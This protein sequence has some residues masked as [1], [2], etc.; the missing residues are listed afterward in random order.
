MDIVVANSGTN[1]IGI[2]LSKIDGTFSNQQT[3]PTGIYSQP[4]S[5]VVNDFNND[6]YL[7]IAVAN[8]GTNNI[9]IFRGYG[10]GS[11][12]SQK[13]FS[14]G[15]S[16]PLFIKSG[17]FN[18]DNRSDIAVANYG[19]NNIGVFLGYGNGSFQNQI[20]SFTGYDSLLY[21]LAVADFNEDNHLDIAIANY[22]IDN[23]GIFLGYGNGSFQSQNT[24][25]TGYG[26]NPSSI[27]VGDFNDDNHLDIVVANNGTGNVGILLGFGNGMF[28]AQT[29]YLININSYPQYIT[30]GDFNKDGELDVAVVNSENDE[31]YILLGSGNGTFATV[32]TYDAISESY[33]ISIAVADFDKDN[34]SD[35]FVAN[36]G[37]NNV[38]VLN[39]YT[40]EPSA[41]QTNYSFGNENQ[42]GSVVV[43]D[44]NNDNYLDIAATGIAK[45]G[46]YLLMGNSNGTF[47]GDMGFS[48][49]I[50][51]LPQQLSANDLNHDNRTDIITVNFG[52]DSVGVLLGQDKGI[53]APVMI[54]STGIGSGPSR[55][56]IADV[57]NDN[58][59]DIITANTNID[60]VGVLLG[61]GNGSFAKVLTFS[62]DIGSRPYAVAVGD[63]NNDNHLDILTANYDSES[64]CILFGDGNST[65][66]IP[67]IFLM[68]DNAHPIS[69]TVA[70]FNSDNCLD[71]ALTTDTD[72]NLHVLF[73]DGNGNFSTQI[74]YRFGSASE[75]MYVI[76]TDFNHDNQMDIVSTLTGID[77]VVILLGYGNGSFQD[78]K[79]Y[80]TGSGSLPDWLAFGDFN[81]NTQSEI[82]VAL[83][84]SGQ[85]A[86]LTEYF[87]AKFTNQ[88]TY[89]TGS[90]PQ[91]YS[92]AIGDFNHDNRSDIVVANSGTDN[93]GIAFGFGNGT[94]ET[95]MMYS[96]G[97]DS[98]PQ[99]VITGDINNDNN[100][101]II[102]ANSKRDSIGMIMGYSNGTFAAET[103]Y[104]TGT[105]SHPSAVVLGDFNNDNRSDLFLVNTGTDSIAT[106]I[107][108]DYALFET[109]KTYGNVE[110]LEPRPIVTS[111][112][113]NDN[114]L[115]I[116][117]GFFS[118][119]TVGILL[120]YGN[121]S[122]DDMMTYPQEN[123]SALTSLAVDDV[124]NDGKL[125]IVVADLGTSNIVILLGYGNGSFATSMTFS[126]GNNSWPSAIAI[127]DFN[128]DDL[129]DVAVANFGSDNVDILLGYGNGSFTIVMAYS[130]GNGSSPFAIAVSDFNKDDRL[131][132]AV[133]NRDTF[134]FGILLGFGNGSFAN[135]VTYVIGSYSIPYSIVVCD[136]DDD[137]QLDIITANYNDDSIGV[138]LG[139][140]DGTFGVMTA[141]S[142]GSGTTPTYV[143][144]GDFNNDN[145]L[146][147][148]VVNRGTD[149][150]I[151]YFQYEHGLYYEGEP[152]SSGIWS[153]PISLAI[154][155]FNNDN[156]L[157]FVTSNLYAN[158]IGV[159]LGYGNALFGSI[160]IYSIISGSQPDAVAIGDFNNDGRSDFVIANYGTNNVGIILGI[161]DGNFNHMKLYPTGAGSAPCSVAVGDFN[162]DNHSDIVVANCKTDNLVILLGFGNG[163]FDTGANYSTGSRSHPQSIA[164][165][166]F[167]NDNIIDIAV[168]NSG[169][170]NILLFYGYEN[171]TFENKES[172]QLGYDYLPYSIAVNDLNQDG[173]MDIVIACYNTDNVEILMKMC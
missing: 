11:F 105:D 42:P 18:N 51:S 136:F 50:N 110:N 160:N 111:D 70:D 33:P 2:L 35:V 109:Q 78:P 102:V 143:T 134:N 28:A 69:I 84:G 101:D 120:G 89:S 37:T 73:G 65:F 92:V 166:D 67:L 59:L 24:Y 87:A 31:L 156:R 27:A 123:G 62:T 169:T 112:F 49:G 1:N 96:T 129:L 6:N 90:A 66:S 137:G 148:A 23:I 63:V 7:D 19:T 40:S 139:Y 9:G 72:G 13:L 157:D 39:R 14:T 93:L 149:N 45:D 172:Y 159:F 115:D 147:I 41:R 5:V 85:I 55:F 21:S 150:V 98:H 131:D 91:P 122:F 61:H 22:D 57:N 94:F 126:T 164:I 46:V 173:W 64:M 10:N 88:T 152:Y 170:S 104:P 71:I 76:A 142:T 38:L 118:S 20:T 86:I 124:N 75:P 25:T 16:H 125:D 32:T 162:D 68:D 79:A 52:T 97:V 81:N 163:T 121:G 145:R 74:I 36:Y 26:S 106:L 141:Y 77:S 135:Q 133:L 158:D 95:Q 82:V 144:V 119:G 155:D 30:I 12:A 146:D 103:V 29:T 127:A 151:V 130:T 165:A 99:Y 128:K 15:S 114:Y 132:I 161:T 60:C 116:A 168:A 53:F 108:Y 171:G 3:Y 8:Y 100:L 113:N 154:G 54:Y 83:E 17:D 107:G 34:Q 43:S 153:G 44:F 56:A 167:N 80:S 140:G 47:G 58:R 117:V 138:F 4:Y 48:T